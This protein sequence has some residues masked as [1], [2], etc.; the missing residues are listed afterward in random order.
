MQTPRLLWLK[1]WNLFWE[2]W[3]VVL[4][5]NATL[6]ALVISWQLVTHMCFPAFSHC[7]NRTFLSK[8]IDYFSHILLQSREAKISQKESSS[9]PGIEL[10]PSGH[11]SDTLTTELPGPA[12]FGKGRKHCRKRRK[13]WLPAF[14]P[15]PTMFS[16]GFLYKV[17][18]S[19]D[20]VVKN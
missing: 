1:N 10:K 11:E 18:E 13:C 3:L 20:C 19:R 9:Q 14:S 6:I 7:T 17:I 5:F 15:F 4:G 8:A 16:K 2:G 12:C